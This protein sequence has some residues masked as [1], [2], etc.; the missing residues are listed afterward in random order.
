[1]SVENTIENIA[2]EILGKCNAEIQTNIRLKYWKDKF[3]EIRGTKMSLNEFK[4][5]FNLNF[6]DLIINE[7]LEKSLSFQY[8]LECKKLI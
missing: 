6:D 2:D 4:I 1:M 3:N 5:L 7:F 8:N